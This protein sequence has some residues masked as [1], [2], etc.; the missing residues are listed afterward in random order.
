M[1]HLATAK[2]GKE[3]EEE[4]TGEEIG[5]KENEKNKKRKERKGKKKKKKRRRRSGP[6][7]LW[8][9]GDFSIFIISFLLLHFLEISKMTQFQ[10]S[11]ISNWPL[12]LLK[13]YNLASNSF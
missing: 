5:G 7:V 4:S 2:E 1:A 6:R 11:K 10:V 3:E 9:L 8:G 12:I 13:F